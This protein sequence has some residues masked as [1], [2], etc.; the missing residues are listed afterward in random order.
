MAVSPEVVSYVNN[1]GARGPWD[2]KFLMYL[3]KYSNKLAYLQPPT[4]L[5]YGSSPPKSHKQ[6]YL[7]F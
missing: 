6:G 4:V 5:V 2:R 7:N 3:L 1:Y